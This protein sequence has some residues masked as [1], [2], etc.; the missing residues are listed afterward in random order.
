M[1]ATG[2]LVIVAIAQGAFL[3][4]LAAVIFIHRSVRRRRQALLGPHV[5]AARAALRQWVAGAATL[6]DFVAVLDRFPGEAAL[7]FTADVLGGAMGAE[8]ANRI[9]ILLRDEAW[10][11]RLVA[12]ASSRL[13]WRRRQAARALA[14]VGRPDDR[15]VLARL[16]DDPRPAVAVMAV[17]AL[18]RVV[19]PDLVG[20]ALDRYPTL[21]AVI[22]KFLVSSLAGVRDL[23]AV[24]LTER[25]RTTAHPRSLARWLELALALEMGDIIERA[26]PLSTHPDARVRRELARALRIRPTVGALNLLG[27]LLTDGDGDVRAAAVRAL[28]QIGIGD[29]AEQLR[30]AAHDPAW[31]VRYSAA[32]AMAQVGDRGRA[33]LR[34]LR[35][36]DD[37]YVA[38][39]A[40]LI[41]GLSDGAVAELASD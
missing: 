10:M 39:M 27:T 37:R 14:I 25:M 21:P 1:T 36:D 20:R 32:L 16:L 30:A 9:A 34:A 41:S 40:T 23:V 13:W 11:Q 4:G 2:V 7:E 26:A 33:A 22:R 31:Q 19:D 28:G 18:P 15:D 17:T 12:M 8:D 24:A 5:D 38:D 3:A 29:A 6:R 35:H